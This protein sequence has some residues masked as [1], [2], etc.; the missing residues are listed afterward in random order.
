MLPFV[1]INYVRKLF[2]ERMLE[3]GSADPPTWKIIQ[4]I[5]IPKEVSSTNLEKYLWI[6]KID[7]MQQWYLRSL[8][9]SYSA[10]LKPSTV[11]TYGFE[12]GRRTS[13]VTNS[14]RSILVFVNTWHRALN[15][16]VHIAAQDVATAFDSIDHDLLKTALLERGVHPRMVLALLREL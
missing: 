7:C 5:G 6:S 1:V 9:R 11:A 8:R 16:E 14:L 10:N 3:P 12:A 15:L 2:A 4:F 13:D